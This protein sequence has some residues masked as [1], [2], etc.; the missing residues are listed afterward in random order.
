MGR[1]FI[2]MPVY[3]MEKY[4]SQAI[5]SLVSQSMEEWTLYISDNASTDNTGIICKKYARPEAAVQ[6]H[7]LSLP[8]FFKSTR[9]IQLALPIQVTVSAFFRCKCT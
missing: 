7:P 2:G 9:R 4:V 5:Q 3:N 8:N 1:V 6:V